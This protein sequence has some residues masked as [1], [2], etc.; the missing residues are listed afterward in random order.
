VAAGIRPKLRTVLADSGYVSEKNF[1][2]ADDD[3]L[4]LLAPL[5]K[6]P[7]RQRSRPP[8]RTRHLDQHPATTRA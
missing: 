5:A 6:G 8:E 3:G 2:R 7:G 4:G 1:A